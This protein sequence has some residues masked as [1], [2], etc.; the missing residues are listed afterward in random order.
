MFWEDDDDAPRESNAMRVLREKAEADSKV[1]REMAEELKGLRAERDQ[2]KVRSVV[3]SKGLDPKVAS[4]AAAA[5]V[6]PNE[7]A[8]EAWLAD[9]GDVFAK[10]GQEPTGETG[11]EQPPVDE[12]P[13][14]EQ[15]ALA[16]FAAA[17]QGSEPAKGLAAVETQIKAADSPEAVLRALGITEGL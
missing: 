13:A 2:E 15:A 4:L 6:E 17:A 1:I 10:A 8:V 14:D 12:V 16:A 11:D 9:F 3:T 5:G 7:Q